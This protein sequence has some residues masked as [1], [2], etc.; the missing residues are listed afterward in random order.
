MPEEMPADYSNV[1]RS[2]Y[3]R[4]CETAVKALEKRWFDARWF[5][6]ID[7]AVEAVLELIPPGSKV[8]AGGSVTLWESGL[9]DMLEERGDELFYHR[10]PMDFEESMA[11]RKEAIICPFYLCSSNA[12]TMEGELLNTDGM[13]NR[14]S[15]MIFGPATVVVIAGANKLVADREAAFTRIREVAAPANAIRYGLDLPCVKQ[16]RC[17]DCREQA[18]I[19]RVTTI[20]SRKPLMTDLKVFLVAEPL[21]F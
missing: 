17:V 18:N 15:G 13:G 12:V 11:V 7:R 19:C 14:V 3:E 9:L 1:R 21:G 20:I 10:P 5:S 4:R 16:G 2:Y 8:G 6:T